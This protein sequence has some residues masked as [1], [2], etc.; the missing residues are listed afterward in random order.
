MSSE[1][2]GLVKY[3]RKDNIIALALTSGD[4][5]LESIKKV[6]IAEN[7]RSATVTGIGA[8]NFV[9]IGILNED[10]RTYTKRTVEEDL[11]ISN[12]TGNVTSRDG[13]CYVHMHITLTKVDNAFGGHIF[14]CVISAVADI[15]IK[16]IDIDIWRE[17]QED[18]TIPMK[19]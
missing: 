2:R 15:F 16:I 4:E 3:K 9:E 7:V 11:E 10:K 13:E 17:V 12:M 19:F 18:G 5:V 8:T 14:R 6:C 1:M